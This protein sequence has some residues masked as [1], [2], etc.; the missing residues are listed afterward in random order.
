MLGLHGV[1]NRRWAKVLIEMCGCSLI[2]SLL[3]NR[4][5]KIDWVPSTIDLNLWI[6]NHFIIGWRFDTWWLIPIILWLNPCASFSRLRYCR[7]PHRLIFDLTF[8]KR[9]KL[10]ILNVVSSKASL[11]SSKYKYYQAWSWNVRN[12]Q[13]PVFV[14]SR[15]SLHFSISMIYMK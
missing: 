4:H 10:Y 11:V 14:C 7:S 2:C 9:S 8:S 13:V 6:Q 15:F 3:P 12:I 5:R 1:C